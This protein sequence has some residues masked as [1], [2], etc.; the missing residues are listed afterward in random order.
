[1][2]QYFTPTNR[3][4]QSLTQVATDHNAIKRSSYLGTSDLFFQQ[5]QLGLRLVELGFE[6]ID[7]TAILSGQRIPV[8]PFNLRFLARPFKKLKP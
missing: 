8:A 1:M 5:I 7:F 2:K 3:R 4:A 6:Y